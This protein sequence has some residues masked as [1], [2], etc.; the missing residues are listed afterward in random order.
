MGAHVEVKE[1]HGLRL[2]VKTTSGPET[3]VSFV[4]A[5]RGQSVIPVVGGVQHAR[6]AETNVLDRP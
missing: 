5:P 2:I 4:N 3:G 1:V 6:L